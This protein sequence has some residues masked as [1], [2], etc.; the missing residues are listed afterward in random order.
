MTT[1]ADTGR[2][3]LMSADLCDHD[4]RASG[5]LVLEEGCFRREVVCECG[6]MMIFLG[7]EDYRVDA[8]QA[9]RA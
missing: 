3:A 6:R 7:R 9:H 4:G 1:L 5:R 2:I 8:R